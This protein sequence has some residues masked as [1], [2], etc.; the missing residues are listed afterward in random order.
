MDKDVTDFAGKALLRDLR[1]Q[2]ETAA[3]I[4]QAAHALADAGL[5]ARAVELA[6][7]AD[8]PIHSAGSLL[9][10]ATTVVRSVDNDTAPAG[11]DALDRPPAPSA[12]AKTQVDPTLADKTA[13][14][15]LALARDKL[16]AAVGVAKAA[17]LCAATG[18]LRACVRA[19]LDLEPM[20][21]D[22][23]RL[24]DAASLVT[25]EASAE[26]DEPLT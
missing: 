19:A 15:F 12:A 9:G 6:N 2:V 26:P 13:R 7:D 11:S 1:E 20:L 17:E 25:R 24:I 23:R 22:A 4:A 5:V 18:N 16:H 8:V 21:F 3:G 10:L 14:A